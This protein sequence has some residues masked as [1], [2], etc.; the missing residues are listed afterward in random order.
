MN[1]KTLDDDS[2]II[3]IYY[4]YFVITLQFKNKKAERNLNT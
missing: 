2:V 1:N 3:K 4:A